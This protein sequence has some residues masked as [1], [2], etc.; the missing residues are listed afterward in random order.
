M[1]A[2]QLSIN[3]IKSIL[4][5]KMNE[6]RIFALSVLIALSFVGN[7]VYAIA[8]EPRCSKFDFEE[9]VLEKLV[10][11]DHETETKTKDLERKFTMIQEEIANVKE[12][13]RVKGTKVVYNFIYGTAIT[14][15]WIN[16]Y[17]S[18]RQKKRKRC[19]ALNANDGEI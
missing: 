19:D 4:S 6:L 9:K 17:F 18:S 14:E 10:I 7:Y 1:K 16:C 3:K 2:Y 5:D 13:L 8:T 15:W 12:E 11:L